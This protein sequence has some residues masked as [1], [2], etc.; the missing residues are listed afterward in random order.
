M[1]EEFG[2]MVIHGDSVYEWGNLT[3]Q[4]LSGLDIKK[5]KKKKR[6]DDLISISV[7]NF[8]HLVKT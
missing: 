3:N 7:W 6:A 8:S 5:K 2:P 1:N 4:K